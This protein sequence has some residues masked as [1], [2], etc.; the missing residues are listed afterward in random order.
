MNITFE[1]L[2]DE[3]LYFS[4]HVHLMKAHIFTDDMSRSMSNFNVKCQIHKSTGDGLQK[5]LGMWEGGKGSV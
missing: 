5:L 4:M 3:T 2:E 1:S